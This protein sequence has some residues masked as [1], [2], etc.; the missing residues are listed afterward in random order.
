MKG[1]PA[2]SRAS[3]CV[4]S[5][6]RSTILIAVMSRQAVFVHGDELMTD[7]T[8]TQQARTNDI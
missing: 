2:R 6:G 4:L 8:Y 5:G 7:E 1:Y 3:P